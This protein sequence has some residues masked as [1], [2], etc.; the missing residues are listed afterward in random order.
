MR[1]ARGILPW[2]ATAVLS[3]ALLPSSSSAQIYTLPRADA[4]DGDFFG[5]AVAIEA[6]RV[7]VGATGV[8][9]CGE[10]SGAAYVYERDTSS[11]RWRLEATLQPS[12]CE[13]GLFFGRSLDLSGNTA[14]V[15]AFRNTFSTIQQNATYVFERD[16]TDGSWHQTA[17]L[18]GDATATEGPFG[19]DVG[20]D[21]DRILVTT[22]GDLAEG[23]FG[24]AGYVF[25]RT[26]RG[27]WNRTARLTASADTKSGILGGS[28]AIDGDRI[29]ISAS[30]YFQ[31]GQ[32]SVYIFEFDPGSERWVEDAR[33]DG[34]EDFFISTRIDNDRIVVGESKAGK[35]S[36]GR[37]T[38]FGKDE[39]G[40]WRRLVVLHPTH[41]FALGAFGSQ[42]ALAGDRVLVVG[43]DEQLQFEFNIDRVVY[44]FEHSDTEN[45]ATGGWSQ[46]H[47][48]D[49]GDVYFGSA[50]DIDNNVAAIGQASDDTPGK[51]VI[52]H[53]H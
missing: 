39:T 18:T 28:A 37:A 47:V 31:R 3:V 25:E 24:G 9:S 45:A 33:L 41:P 44:V 43:Y 4:A 52:V 27:Q 40:R 21:G 49:V 32:G 6:D 35:D 38:V 22:A 15:A 16:T 8:S 13:P 19:A 53:L 11:G 23:K 5:V 29:V 12:D 36:E 42:V 7:L 10:N 34:F 1:L 14:V 50:I 51:V 30:K 17:R 20:I 48:I 2:V 26:R 46:K